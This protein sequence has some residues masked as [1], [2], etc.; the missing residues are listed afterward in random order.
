MQFRYEESEYLG[1]E[2]TP[3]G[4]RPAIPK[5]T[6]ISNAPPPESVKGIRQFIGLCG[7][8]RNSIH[9][10]AKL[11]APLTR[12]TRAV[13]RYHYGQLPPEVVQSYKKLKKALVSH[14]LLTFPQPNR[15]FAL[16]VDAS[17]LG[18]GATLVQ[19]DNKGLPH[20]IF[21]ASRQVKQHEM[22]Y[23]SYLMEMA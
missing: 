4:Y 13:S 9:N 23:N 16:Y 15:P 18:L 6:A 2:V 10:F 20:P 3:E 11:A 12:C 8:F 7:F 14:P 21:Y 22:S 5:T 17:E 19:R 1:Y